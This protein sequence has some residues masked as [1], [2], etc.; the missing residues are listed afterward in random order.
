MRTALALMIL[1]APAHAQTAEV[2]SLPAGCDAY[3]TIQSRSCAVDHHFTCDADPEGVKRRVSL[4][5]EGMTYL[6]STDRET[7]WLNSFHPLSNHSERLE[8][9]P[10][11][12]AS[13]SELLET[14]R[15]SYDFVT[16]SDEVGPTRYVGEDRL[17][18]NLVTI[19][20]V[21]L[22]ETEYEI[23]AYA[24]DG[25]EMWSSA[26]NEFVSERFRTF[27]GGTGRVTVPGDSY[28]KDDSPVEF[29][30]PGE[31]GFLSANP[32]HDCGV[33]MSRLSIPFEGEPS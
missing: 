13:L 23:T 32:K 11:D 19:D 22:R 8:D 27:L 17:I 29:I 24:P 9:S 15:D 31:P 7:Q 2:F 3:L 6:G 26:G 12:P 10:A 4:S 21:T 30:F 28:E 20:D 18:G 1:A 25:T 16:L 14:G 33:M 5:E